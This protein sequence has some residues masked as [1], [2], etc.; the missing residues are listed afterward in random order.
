MNLF[1]TLTKRQWE[2]VE[3]IGFGYSMKEAAY[4]LGISVETVKIHLKTIYSIIGIQKA[5]ELAKFLYCR[6]FGLAL[7]MCEPAK[8][9][10]ALVLMFIFV[11]SLFMK[12]PYCRTRVRRA[13]RVERVSRRAYDYEL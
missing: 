8:R 10:G 7:E 2:I 6:R 3:Y 9:M 5:T 13:N 4:D 1:A 12:D 11:G